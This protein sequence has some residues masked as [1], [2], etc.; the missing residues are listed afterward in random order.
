MTYLLVLALVAVGV[1]LGLGY[2]KRVRTEVREQAKAE[3]R[4]A[5]VAAAPLIELGRGDEL[6]ELAREA[7]N[8]VRGRVLIV[9]GAGVVLS[10]SAG[11]GSLGTSYATRPEV[12]SALGGQAVQTERESETLNQRLLVT[13]EPVGEE[14]RLGA[15]R[16][17]QDTA[18]VGRAVRRTT[19]AV[20]L[21]GLAVLLLGTLVAAALARRFSRPLDRLEEAAQQIAE[22]DLTV[23]AQPEGSREQQALATS[24]NTMTERVGRALGNQRAFVAD[25][26]HQL[27]TPL[28]G[29]RLRIEAAQAEQLPD[30]AARHL[31]AATLEL[32]RLAEM[33]D[34]LLLLS[35]TGERDAPGT[36]LDLREIVDDAAERWEATL[37]EREQ[38]LEVDLGEEHPEAFAAR[39]DLD[40][41]IDGLV[42]NASR[43]SPPGALVTL[44]LRG[45]VVEVEDDGPGISGEELDTVFERFARGS[46]GLAAGPGTGLGLPIARELIR[47]WGG[48]VTLGCGAAGGTLAR[49]VLPARTPTLGAD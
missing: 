9:D 38:T 24:F 1:P 49:V 14:Q 20:V 46:A 22:G 23:R 12:A 43:Y 37:A 32:D 26:S 6:D 3:A 15:V 10:D 8:S 28:A 17:S 25:A 2:G 48:D 47:R 31:D 36:V 33:I 34:E 7:A 19:L 5:A 13:A 44:R 21:V 29:M 39:S 11:R 30:D 18:A 27:R 35:R 42:E 45:T 40:R 4:I 16:I 41:A